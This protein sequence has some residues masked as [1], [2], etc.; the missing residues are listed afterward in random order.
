MGATLRNH[1]ISRGG[2]Y[3][4]DDVTSATPTFDT[5][6]VDGNFDAFYELTVTDASGQSETCGVTITVIDSDL[7]PDC[8]NASA[9]VPILW[10]PNHKMQEIAV[11]GVVDTKD[12]TVSLLVTGV[13]QDEPTNGLG[14]GDMSPDAAIDGGTARVR[15]ERSG[16]G[17]GRVYMIEFVAS[18]AL[19]QACWGAVSVGVPHDKKQTPVDSGQNYDS[20]VD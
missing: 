3:T 17:D 20:T 11:T 19:G 13:T 12:P 5:P 8:S 6:I 14:D 1:S 10:P 15:A 2:P 7:P 16:L 18:D 4:L 9:S